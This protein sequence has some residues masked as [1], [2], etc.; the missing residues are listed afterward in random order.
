MLLINLHFFDIQLYIYRFLKLLT[1]IQQDLTEIISWFSHI[2]CFIPN[3]VQFYHYNLNFNQ[4]D[5][6]DCNFYGHGDR[7]SYYDHD[8]VYDHDYHVY[9]SC[10]ANVCDYHDLI[11]V[12]IFYYDHDYDVHVNL[13]V[14]DDENRD[15]DSLYVLE[16]K[17]LKQIPKHL[18]H[19]LLNDYTFIHVY[20]CDGCFYFFWFSFLNDYNLSD[21]YAIYFNAHDDLH[22]YDYDVNFIYDHDDDYILNV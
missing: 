18:W 7:V 11:Y 6:Y 16:F 12:H 22:D 10:C 2:D 20:V 14:R 1:I 9:A 5:V 3:Q 15:Y 21:V 13:H 17:Y 8:Y 4:N 19:Y